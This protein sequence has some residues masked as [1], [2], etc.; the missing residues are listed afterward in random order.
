[1]SS[2]VL[3]RQIAPIAMI[4]YFP[5]GSHRRKSTMST[6]QSG[7]GLSHCSPRRTFLSKLAALG[8]AGAIP[9]G[10][11]AQEPKRAPVA[12]RRKPYRIDV[13]HHLMYPGYLEEIAGRRAGSTF[14]WSPAMSIEDMDKSGIAASILSLIQPS[15]SIAD[16]EK[17]RRVARL[18]N[19]FCAQLARDYPGRF[20][21]F[22]TIPLLDAEGSLKE[23]EY[24]LD[25]LKAHGI[26]LMTSYQDK[27]LGDG[28]FAPVWEEL[29]RRKAVVYTHP[30]S[31]ECCRNIKSEV[32]PA[33]VEYATDTTRTIASL[34]FSGTVARYPDIRWIFSHSG[35]TMPFLLSRF[36]RQE[37]DMKEK[38]AQR[39]PKVGTDF[40]FR[41]GAEEIGG[42]AAYGF[43]PS[44]LRAIERE[45]ALRLLPRL[46]A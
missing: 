26:S 25:T 42:L 18:S 22:A 8:A 37:I 21:S 38:A 15:A 19:E 2:C 46:S 3:R 12:A 14:N 20:A 44:D 5:R 40:P 7:A 24:A 6:S 9:G 35:G 45:N 29:N 27:Y 41:D 4:G 16:V 31:P 23:I 43:V 13:H 28:A 30:L 32:P 11:T 36:V 34:V 10:L 1:M 17:G 33:V 39:M